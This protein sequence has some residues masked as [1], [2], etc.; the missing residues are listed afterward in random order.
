MNAHQARIQRLT[1][2]TSDA[3]SYDRYASWRGVVQALARRNFNDQQI[4]AIRRYGRATS[5]DLLRL[6]DAQRNFEQEELDD[7]VAGTF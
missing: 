7:L 6:L 3:Y 2:A 1:D 4:E 5:T